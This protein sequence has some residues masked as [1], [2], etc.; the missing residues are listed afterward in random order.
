MIPKGTGFT[1]A[2]VVDEAV[3]GAAIETGEARAV[4]DPAAVA[5]KVRRFIFES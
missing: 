2:P 4:V 1:L 5:A 3:A